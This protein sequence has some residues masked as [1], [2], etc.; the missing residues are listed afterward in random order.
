MTLASLLTVLTLAGASFVEALPPAAQVQ[1]RAT[2]CNGHAELCNKL[3]SNVTYIGTHNSYAI[4]KG[5][6]NVAANQAQTITAQLNAG[7]RLLQAQA[8][9]STNSS[10]TGI[11]VDLCH[12]SCSLL[13]GGAIENWLTQIKTWVDANPNEVLSLLIVNSDSVSPATYAQAFESTGLASKMYSPTNPSSSGG[14]AKSS[15]PTLSSM[16]DS[17]KTVVAYLDNSADVSTTP[18]LLPEFSSMWENPYD[19]TSTP[20]N[21][22]IDRSGQGEDTS[23][24]MYLANHVLTSST[25]LGTVPNTGAIY[26]TNSKASVL[27]DANQCASQHGSSYPT[28]VLVDYYDRPENDVF[29]AAAVMNGVSF[30]N[31]TTSSSSSSSSNGNKG[32]SSGAIARTGSAVPTEPLLLAATSALA[33]GLVLHLVV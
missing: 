17:G 12:T 23:T 18:Y 27:Q 11:G 1:R 2:T 25:I 26:S 28:F 32:S 4:G 29:A 22:S 20:F 21:C 33:L 3:Y 6:S 8:H 14:V 9:K 31:T 19:Q 15:W 24:Q 5:T 16:I 30:T 10:T 7:V 13:Q